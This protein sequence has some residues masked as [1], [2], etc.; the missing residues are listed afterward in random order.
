M[1]DYRKQPVEL[2][3]EWLIR[4]LITEYLRHRDFGLAREFLD[5]LDE[6]ER[7]AVIQGIFWYALNHT[8]WELAEHC[9]DA[10]YPIAPQ[11]EDVSD[12]GPLNDSLSLIGNR[13]DVVQWL[14]EHGAEVDRRGDCNATVLIDAAGRG[15]KDI[16][17]LLLAKGAD[18][19]A[20][21]I[22]DDDVTALMC[23]AETGHCEIVETLLEY[24]A[25]AKRKNRWGVDAAQLAD[26]AGNDEIAALIRNWK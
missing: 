17:D 20:G 13:V 12:W 23:A 25:D 15:F 8:D 6:I 21:T 3:A 4:E 10:G 24:G 16:V 2:P 1:N 26:T 14:L 11:A 5:D 9:I 22:V 18:V 7:D 19:D